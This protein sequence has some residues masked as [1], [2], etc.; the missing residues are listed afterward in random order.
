[1]LYELSL[2]KDRITGYFS[3]MGYTSSTVNGS[4]KYGITVYFESI[5]MNFVS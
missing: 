5:L 4:T 1:M 2:R 3:A